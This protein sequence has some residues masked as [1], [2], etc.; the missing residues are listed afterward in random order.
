MIPRL[1][2]NLGKAE[3]RQVL[4]A[5]YT[6]GDFEGE[7]AR[8]LG[9][10]H[11]VAFAY[12]RTAMMALF[13]V[14]GIKNKEII[15]PSYTCVVVAHAIVLSGNTPVFVDSEADGYNMCL[16]KVR[17]A[18]TENTAAII[19]TSIH[20]FPVDIDR[21]VTLTGDF[22]DI[23]IF[24]D[25]AHSFAA[26]WQ[27]RPV[28]KAG[29]ASIFAFNFSKIATSVFG[30]IIAT[31]D[32]ALAERLRRFRDDRSTQKWT[33]ELTA[34]LYFAAASLALSPIFFG[35]VYR[36]RWLPLI[37]HFT[38]YYE[39]SKIDM[40]TDYWDSMSSFE[41]S[42]G[43]VQMSRYHDLIAH[44]VSIASVYNT[45]LADVPD[46]ELPSM[47]DGGTFSH[48]PVL[49]KDLPTVMSDMSRAGYELG[50]IIDYCIPDMAAYQKYQKDSCFERTR[51]IN[52]KVVNLPLW[53]DKETALEIASTFAKIIQRH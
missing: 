2:P 47:M 46:A 39:E 38:E 30:G 21:L 4:R 53:V 12:G 27:G 8:V 5:H 20:G 34:R 32:S 31:D 43:H 49:V 16:E 23:Q 15:C 13:D 11:S 1:R 36:L 10:R 41:A 22:P 19:V 52:R 7:C 6:V 24:Q 45:A 29:R 44:R 9:V 42:V 50:R 28:H 35:I 3:W 17:E 40:P 18:I 26:K 51:E 25:C 14:A 37:R 33:R 48:Y